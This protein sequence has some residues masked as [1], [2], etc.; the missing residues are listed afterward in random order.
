MIAFTYWL[1][2]ASFFLRSA[3]WAV[4]CFGVCFF[5]W[6]ISLIAA[7]LPLASPAAYAVAMV[8]RASFSFSASASSLPRRMSD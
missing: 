6:L 1:V 7:C 3:T 5:C 8:E 2:V 4:F